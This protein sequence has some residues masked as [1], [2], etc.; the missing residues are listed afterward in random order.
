MKNN[1]IKILI[2]MIIFSWTYVLS[3]RTPTH[4]FLKNGSAFDIVYKPLPAENDLYQYGQTKAHSYEEN[5]ISAGS[6]KKISIGAHRNPLR[7]SIKRIGYGSGL[8]SWFDVPA[9]EDLAREQLTTD[10]LAAYE[11]AIEAGKLPI[12]IIRS[13]YLGGWSFSIGYM[14]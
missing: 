1:G 10:Q 14:K 3:A 13:S 12:I 5:R 9:P 6:G 7:L 11:R 8:S 4:I 2:G